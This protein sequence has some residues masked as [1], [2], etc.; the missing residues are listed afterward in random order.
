M[1]AGARRVRRG[2][3]DAA[4]RVVRG[5]HQRRTLPVQRRHA[6]GHGCCAVS[7]DTMWREDL[8]DARGVG[9]K[10]RV[11]QPDTTCELHPY[12][13]TVIKGYTKKKMCTIGWACTPPSKRIGLRSVRF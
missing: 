3:V 9:P 8:S 1:R 5:M 2:A 6:D 12:A 10:A 4:S 13:K 11:R 7:R